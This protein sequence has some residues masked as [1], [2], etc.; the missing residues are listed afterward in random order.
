TIADVHA[1]ARELESTIR[2][3]LP[4]AIDG[5]VVKVNRLTLQTELGVVGGRIPRW[6]VARKFA[7]DIAET[8]LL[9]IDVQVGR[10]GARTPRAVPGGAAAVR[11][12]GAGG[13]LRCA[14]AARRACARRGRRRDDHLRHAAQLRPRGREGPAHRRCRAGEACRRGDSAD[15]RARARAP[16]R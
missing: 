10:T 11:S 1:W 6:A 4:F 13:R 8:T 16:R 12:R 7:P 14:D 15:P 9:D 3:E 2:P 5:G